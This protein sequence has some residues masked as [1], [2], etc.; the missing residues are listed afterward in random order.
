[1]LTGWTPDAPKR[2]F[3]DQAHI[4]IHS[5]AINPDSN[6][7]DTRPLGDIVQNGFL[8]G[9]SLLDNIRGTSTTVLHEVRPRNGRLAPITI[10]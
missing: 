7:F 10:V 4:F 6:Q 8:P 9:K 3:G 5:D 2:D 1:M